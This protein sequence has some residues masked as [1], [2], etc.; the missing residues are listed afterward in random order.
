MI[1]KKSHRDNG[2][3]QTCSRNDAIPLRTAT[4]SMAKGKFKNH[5]FLKLAVIIYLHNALILLGTAQ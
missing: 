2:N 4:T 3:I 1:L 5:T